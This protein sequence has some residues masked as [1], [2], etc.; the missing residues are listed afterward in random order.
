MVVD[1]VDALPWLR[2]GIVDVLLAVGPSGEEDGT[3]VDLGSA[4]VVAALPVG[5]PRAESAA[6][7]VEWLARRLVIA[8]PPG[9]GRRFAGFWTMHD[10]GA[11]TVAQ[12]RTFSTVTGGLPELLRQIVR[13]GVVGLWPSAI[14]VSGGVVTRQVDPGWQAPLPSIGPW[15]AGSPVRWFAE[16]QP[17][18]RS[19]TPCASCSPGSRRARTSGGARLVRRRPRRHLYRGDGRLPA[20]PCRL[21][22]RAV[23]GG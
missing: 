16:H 19:S 10:Q 23:A 5:H 13:T 7:E 11:P 15:A 21:T 18:P 3:V 2:Q 20:P 6:V 22:P 8:P 9:L 12:L 1:F 4:P 14:P 17:V